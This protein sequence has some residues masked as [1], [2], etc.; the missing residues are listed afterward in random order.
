MESVPPDPVAGGERDTTPAREEL[1]ILVLA[2]T[3]NDAKLTANFLGKA[4]I[5]ATVC[6]D[7]DALDARMSEGCG[8]L[9]LAEESLVNKDVGKLVAALESQPS[10]SDL[11]LVL[12]TAPGESAR[13]RLR[14]LSALGVVGNISIIERPV[15]PETLLSTCRVA[16]R[17]RRRQYQVRDLLCEL[18]EMMSQIQQQSRIFN[19]TFSAIP[20]F[21]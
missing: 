9:V 1:G 13:L 17:S 18:E 4:G 3:R 6:A 11:P 20:D 7:L 10:W 19:T 12:I 21:A 16:L 5:G 2:P 8:A 14:H 15:R